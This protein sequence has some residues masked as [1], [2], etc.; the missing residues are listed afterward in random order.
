MWK[1]WRTLTEKI[2]TTD[3]AQ[4]KETPCYLYPPYFPRCQPYLQVNMQL[5]LFVDL[6]LRAASFHTPISCCYVFHFLNNINARPGLDSMQGKDIFV[7]QNVQ[8]G[9]RVRPASYQTR[10]TDSSR[11][12]PGEGWNAVRS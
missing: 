6:Y 8:V 3:Q 12:L 9:S 4:R 2:M 7:F 11:M 5:S 1:P 10:K